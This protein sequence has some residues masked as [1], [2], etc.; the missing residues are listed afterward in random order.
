V[1]SGNV[2]PV[3]VTN[4]PWAG[5]PGTA[6]VFGGSASYDPN[7]G[8]PL[9]DAIVSYEWDLDGDGVFNEANGN[10]GTPVVAGN[11]ANVS[12]VFPT[13]TS[14][15]ATLRVKDK[16]GSIGTSTSQYVSIAVV[17]AQTYNACWSNRL[18]RNVTQRG[19]LVQ[20]SNVGNAT[21]EN[22]VVRL[23]SV[24]SNLTIVS[25]TARLGQMNAAQV[26]TTACNAA[27]TP[28]TAE[29]VL[30]LDTRIVPTGNWAWSAEFDWNSKH[31][32]IPNL[33]PLGP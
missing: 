7:A 4:G 17:F 16:Y 20:F 9:N 11:Y 5:V 14:G 10:D 29:L 25:G 3:A 6:V 23:T 27:S 31:Y 33:P 12:M 32:I 26:K 15:L 24:P 21:A 8:A 19:L 30:D 28:K 2:A 18:N 1:K 13:P 22:V